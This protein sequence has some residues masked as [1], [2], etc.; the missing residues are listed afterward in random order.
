MRFVQDA[1]PGNEE[2]GFAEALIGVDGEWRGIK[3]EAMA[4][5]KQVIDFDPTTQIRSSLPGTT[6]GRVDTASQKFQDRLEER[7]PMATDEGGQAVPASAD[8]TSGDVNDDA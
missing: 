4:K 6:E 8:A 7:V 2:T 3:V 1:V 5:E